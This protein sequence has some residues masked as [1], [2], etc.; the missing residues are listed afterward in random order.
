MQFHALV[1]DLCELDLH[2]ES[3][4]VFLEPANEY[5]LNSGPRLSRKAHE[6]GAEPRTHALHSTEFFADSG[7]LPGRSIASGKI[8][9]KRVKPSVIDHDSTIHLA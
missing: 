4:A 3:V 9:W 8:G 7:E 2:I 1:G 5:A 6:E